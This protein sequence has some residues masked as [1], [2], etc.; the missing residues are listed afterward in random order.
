MLNRQTRLPGR[1]TVLLMSGRL[2]AVEPVAR[3]RERVRRQGDAPPAL[4]AAEQ[5]PVNVR[6][7]GP[8]P[9][10]LIESALPGGRPQK[11]FPPVARVEDRG[12]GSGAARVALVGVARVAVGE[13]RAKLL[14]EVVR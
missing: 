4:S 11:D 13:P 10:E 5:R 1:L 3:A 8:E 2:D 6:A 9:R 14:R 12:G 7:F